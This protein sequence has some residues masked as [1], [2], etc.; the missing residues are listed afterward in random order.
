MFT[1]L[2]L[3]FSNLVFAATKTW[4][5]GGANNNWSTCA[6]WN[7][8][9]CPAAGDTV[10]FDGT[11][12]KDV[13]VDAGFAGTIAVVQMNTGYSG[14]ITLA[15]SFTVTSTFTQSAGIF[16]GSN[17]TMSVTGTFTLNSGASF[18]STSGTLT[19]SGSATINSAATFNNNGGIVTF[20]GT[21]TVTWACGNKTFNSVVINRTATG[22]NSA[23]V[24]SDC[25]LPLGANPTVNLGTQGTF[26]INGTLSGSGTLTIDPEATGFTLASTSVLNGFNGLIS[27][28]VSSITGLNADFSS[29]TT[30]NLTGSL[31]MTL[32]TGA[33]I[34]LPVGTGTGIN[35][36]S[37]TVNTGTTFNSTS[38]TLNITGSTTINSGATFNHNSG[39]VTFTGTGNA[40]LT[41]GNKTFNS[42]VINRTASGVN[43]FSIGGDCNLPIGA[44]PT[45]NLGV[46]T[47]FTMSGILSGTGTLTIDPD[48]TSLAF[49]STTSL[50]GFNGFVSPGIT[51]I[52]GMN[53]DFSSYTTFN[54]TGSLG[55]T[56]STGAS[57]TLP[58]GTGTGIN[59][60]A[61]TVNTGTAFTSS[62]G[63]I[64]VASSMTINSGAT[65]NH[66][67]GSITF[68]GT[69]NT[70]LACGSKLLNSV[71]IN[72]SFTSNL[73]FTVGSDCTLPIG[74]S[75]TISLGTNGTLN[76]NGTLT[77]SGTLTIDPDLTSVAFTS[78][79]VLSGF[80]GFVS[81]G[82][83]SITGMNADFSGY[84]TFNLTGG[85][86]TSLSTGASLTLPAPTGTGINIGALTINTGT[87]FTASPGIINLSAGLSINSGST[88]NHNNGTLNFNGS[89]DF[90]IACGNKTL[91]LVT[92]NM[93]GN[94]NDVT[95]GS[96]C[97]IP[98]G[99]N[100]NVAIGTVANNNLV[101]NGT[102]SG[103]GTLTF[104]VATSSVTINSTGALSGFTGLSGRSLTIA[105][106]T[107]D[108]SSFSPFDLGG[109]LNIT[110]G[111]ITLPST[112]AVASASVSGGTFNSGNSLSVSGAMTISGGTFNAGALTSVGDNFTVSGTPIFNA[113]G[114]EFNFYGVSAALSCN[115]IT[116]GS[117][118]F[119]GQTQT[120][121]VNSTCT[122]PLG[123]NPTIPQA[124]TLNGVLT[125]TGT[126]TNTAGTIT[127]NT[128]SNITGFTGFSSGGALTIA[129][130]NI[131]FSSHTST[132]IASNLTLTS[133]SFIGGSAGDMTIGGNLA[134]S[135][136]TF[137]APGGNLYI[138]GNFNHTSGT[139]NHNNGTVNLNGGNQ[140]ITGT[141]TFYN[142]TKEVTTANT[143]ILTIPVTVTQTI[144]N[145]LTLRG[146]STL[147]RLQLRSSGTPT[148]YKIDPQGSRDMLYID[149]KDG[150]N[151]NA[152][153]LQLAGTGSLD[154]GNNTNFGFTNTAPDNPTSL[155]PVSVVSGNSIA[156]YTP[157][158]TFTIRDTAN[159][160]D[161]L[162]Y[163][164][165]LSTSSDFTGL[166]VDYSSAQSTQGSKTFTVGQAVGTGTYTVGSS[167]QSLSVGSYY[168]R[169]KSTDQN[170]AES[171]YTTAN[172][173]NIA[174]FI[175][176]APNNPSSLGPTS[177]VNGSIG[178]NTQP[179]LTFSITDPDIG[180]TVKYKIEI[181]SVSNFS[182][183]VVDYTSALQTQ[184]STSFTIG[185]AAGSG[186]YSSGNAGQS[187]T[188]GS[189]YWR[190]KAIDVSLVES[191]Y[192]TAN[193]GNIAFIVN[194]IP[195]APTNLGPTSVIDGSTTVNNQPSFT[196]DISDSDVSDTVKYQIQI[197]DSSNFASPV[198]TYTSALSVQGSFSFT[199]GQAAG[200]G[201]YSVGSSGQTLSNA[202]YYW[203][204]RS[205]D[206]NNLVSSYTTAN[207]GNIAFSIGGYPNIPSNLGPSNMIDASVTT[208]NQPSLTFDITDP[209][210]LDTVKYQIQIDDTSNFTT[211]IIDYVSDLQAQGTKTFTIG[212]PVGTGTYNI[213]TE[214]QLLNSDRYYWRVKAIDQTS[215]ESSYVTGG[216]GFEVTQIPYVPSGLGPSNLVDGSTSTDITPTLTFTI[217]D[218]DI[219]DS[220][221]YNIVV[222][223]TSD[224]TSLVAN[225]T[226]ANLSQGF[227]SYTTAGLAS[228]SY[229]WKV[230]TI[231]QNNI[232]S[233]FTLANN[234]N[235]AF[236][237]ATPPNNPNSLGPTGLVNGST[238]TDT[239]PQFT[240][241]LHD[242]DVS[243]TVKYQLQLSTVSNFSS[244]VIDYS[245]ALQAQGATSFTVGQVAGLGTY[246]VGSAGQTLTSNN[247]YWRV[248]ATDSTGLTSSF[249]TARSG[250]IAFVVSQT[251][252]SPANLGPT[253]VIDGSVNSNTQPSFSFDITDP[254]ISDQVKYQIQI[255]DSSNF[256]S[257]VVTYTSVLQTQGSATFTVG[258]AT[259]SGTYSAGSAGQTIGNAS[260]Y[261]RVKT[262]D[263]HGLES[264]YSTANS[265][266]IAFE[267]G[268]LP[269]A[270]TNLGPSNLV[271]GSLSGGSQP[272]LTFSIT[273]PDISDQVKYQIQIDDSSNF[274]SL[275]IDYTSD[276]QDQGS[277]SFTVGQAAGSGTYA[278]GAEG[279]NLTSG[280]Y[281]WRVKTIDQNTNQSSYTT[282]RSGSVAFVLSQS[283]NAPAS[284]GPTNLINGS[285]DSDTTPTL[286][287]NLSDPDASD[288]VRFQIQIDNNSDFS[289]PLVNYTSGT[290]SQGARSFTVGQAVGTGSYSTGNSG[291][292]LLS[293]N[294]YWRVKT[295]DSHGLESSYTVANGGNIAF[296]ITSP[297]DL[298][299]NIGP[300]SV[301]NGSTL[302]SPQPSFIFDLSDSDAFDL[303]QYQFQLSTISDFST[304][305]ID[306]TSELQIQDAEQFIVGQPAGSGTYTIGNQGQTLS[307]A[308]YY[309]RVRTIDEKGL[310]SN[311][312]V[313]NSG[314]VAFKI[315]QNP[316]VPS[317]LGP[318]TYTQGS[319]STDT[320]PTFNFTLGDPDISDTLRYQIQVA[321]NSSFSSLLVDYTS[322]L[323][324]Q[325]YKTFTVGQATSGGSYAKGSVGQNL[326]AGNFYWRVR[327]IDQG[328]IT[329]EYSLSNS[330]NIAFVLSTP[331][332]TPVETTTDV[333]PE[334]LPE[335]P[336][337]EPTSYPEQQ[338]GEETD[339]ETDSENTST[340]NQPNN[341][342][343]AIIENIFPTSYAGVFTP[344]IKS[345][346][347][348]V[349]LDIQIDPEN[350]SSEDKGI[351]IVATAVVSSAV[352]SSPTILLY[353][354][355]VFKRSRKRTWGV[356]Y[357]YIT[358]QP[359]AFA[360]IRLY[361]KDGEFIEQGISD[362][363]GRYKLLQSKGNYK[364]EV[365]HSDFEKKY[366]YIT[367]NSEQSI[368]LDIALNKNENKKVNLLNSINIAR[369]FIQQNYLKINTLLFFLG[370]IFSLV[371]IINNPNIVNLIVLILFI[372]QIIKIRYTSIFVKD[373]G[374]VYNANTNQPIPGVIVRVYD[375]VDQTLK[376][377]I[378]TDSKGRFKFNLPKGNYNLMIVSDQYNLS[379]RFKSSQIIT[380][381]ESG[382]EFIQ[383]NTKSDFK[384][385]LKLSLVKKT[386]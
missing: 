173:G 318:N 76:M 117:V 95:I 217:G 209:D 265:G 43:S 276:L 354:L 298:P 344:F 67:N 296:E 304:L 196:F 129:G 21:G 126:L 38:G 302:T 231:D 162:S 108:F 278:V 295:I 52:T 179:T 130:A 145:N 257:P 310:I 240:F 226:S 190:V 343:S 153:S 30:F 363:Y 163:R 227:K 148:Q 149:A 92:F 70:T 69:G 186:T 80:N 198:I 374:Y 20:A 28:G 364:I 335:T 293:N 379:D 251:P 270:P 266:N 311:F 225:F 86:S 291:Q 101:V 146:N 319:S 256:A 321:D 241:T 303:V 376:D 127:A 255:D 33:S 154:S 203:R 281:Y 294:Y 286:T 373:W 206:N 356:I 111:S 247:Y 180:D 36:A 34:T 141:T 361:N 282:A 174:F 268:G 94:T 288:T 352:I 175:S 218:P 228:G 287:F 386:A 331:V 305:I 317:D 312:K 150:N 262:V 211:P 248:M 118:T 285:I 314:N 49:A 224:Y 245:S 332:T 185:Q 4:D 134:L 90:S 110:S 277:A 140:T 53:A 219:S 7:L 233:D 316:F 359:I 230:R 177:Y 220:V 159:P 258:Q 169:V 78:T 88:F 124:I 87:T 85:F 360:T 93:T 307:S 81:P 133:G 249:T 205:T 284:L 83:S 338:G 212:Q 51:T 42:V 300:A 144:L 306:Y 242:N 131:D 208:D 65:F 243:D 197:D 2:A 112:V 336:V 223:S 79:S 326:S 357:D 97:N 123:N 290:S 189:Y 6:N 283:P 327:T 170:A 381:S 380:K 40:T 96:D 271:D 378:I 168:W 161:T 181:S 105:G 193:S 232:A 299:Q 54:L 50:S 214:G 55:M 16:N 341:F 71:T 365:L 77:G 172:S 264:S 178:S 17:Q 237:I 204:V 18:T 158:F 31:G 35:L 3:A 324:S 73:T 345:I 252:N 176:G 151:V 349:N 61:L 62:S 56:L 143:Y 377:T 297:P 246:T 11:S 160:L 48:I 334:P 66:N 128:G 14:T 273:D 267:I 100:P 210:A 41:C 269:N 121:T 183:L 236:V 342:V 202:S 244:L 315:T 10:V 104:P 194:A 44:N 384:I 362:I 366:I 259:G 382:K 375:R 89:S 136:G 279:Q 235:V 207:S 107:I 272:T 351:L 348:I 109:S 72:K 113:N 74:S 320:T 292:V 47:Q 322:S 122:L 64:N 339:S 155:G 199:V 182:S 19:L 138:A 188:S 370:S 45:I 260:Y 120:K 385:N 280:N 371:S 166:V 165:Q 301:T 274:A 156:S 84:T 238:T 58:V 353:G 350:V 368:G 289:S 213:G 200:T 308:S 29:Y 98:L 22:V 222:S 313:A 195:N 46:N 57:I 187:L 63:N 309:W 184:G 60:G 147:N 261:W 157:S 114:G 275:V 139:F 164:F 347:D 142:L 346:S 106:A 372:I 234:G 215:L 263:A 328:G 132:S 135:N 167:G 12:S 99:S 137:T 25:T 216:T 103:S 152:S 201:T 330:G 229:Y 367:L 369:R 358:N 15:R 221:K 24:G 26:N 32:S 383:L 39:I 102:L 91:N 254:D 250:S 192:T 5:G 115:N 191:G 75:P 68:N 9:T 116:F 119:T 337:E 82:I 329:S 1:L 323:Q 333:T 27:P 8:D 325:G 355:P 253:N 13:T 37:L 239:Q 59:I 171:A 340:Q 125:G 23:T